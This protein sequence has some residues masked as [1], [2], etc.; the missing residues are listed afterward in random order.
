MNQ[1]VTGTSTAFLSVSWSVSVSA[2]RKSG[3]VMVPAPWKVS[4]SPIR[5]WMAV[6]A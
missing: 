5:F 6:G 3:D 2:I 4:L 1:T